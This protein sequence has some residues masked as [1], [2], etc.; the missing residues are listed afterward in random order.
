MKSPLEETLDYLGVGLLY[1]ICLPFG[2]SCR[3]IRDMPLHHWAIG[4]LVL[5][6]EAPNWQRRF[7]GRL[8]HCKLDLLSWRPA[9]N[10]LRR[11]AT[12]RRSNSDSKIF[13]DNNRRRRNRLC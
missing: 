1:V 10:L 3:M 8:E 5:G 12:T 13:V 7:I 2:V 9:Q 6:N 4:T 11:R